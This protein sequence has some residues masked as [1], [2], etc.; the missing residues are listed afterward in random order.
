MNE[1]GERKIKKFCVQNWYDKSCHKLRDSGA[2]IHRHFT[3][4]NILH[5]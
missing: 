1:P 4:K 5:V 2:K 3:R